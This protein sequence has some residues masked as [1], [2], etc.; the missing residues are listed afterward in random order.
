MVSN[1]HEGDD[2]L[3]VE[4]IA[5]MLRERLLGYAM[6]TWHGYRPA[7][8]HRVIAAKLEAVERGEIK[9][10][11]IFMPPRHGKTALASEYFPAWYLGRNAERQIIH[12]TY[13][14]E[15]A[16]DL[17]MK[18]R[19]QLM[20]PLY[21]EIFPG[22]EL[23]MTSRAASRFNTSNGGVYRAVGA[24][25][26]ITGR[27]AHLLLV[28]DPI[29]GRED[30]DSETMR[31]RLK[32]WY[33]SVAYTRLMPGGAVVIIQCMTGDTPV[34]MGDG[35]VQ[36]LDCLRP[37]DEVAT[38]EC[39]ELKKSTVLNWSSNGKDRIHA[40]TT[41]SGKIV[42]AN[43]RHP[44]LV[45]QEGKWSWVQLKN[46]KPGMAL[47]SLRDAIDHQELLQ[48]QENAARA[49]PRTHTEKS[50][51]APPVTQLGITENGKTLLAL[52]TGA[53]NPQNAKACV[54]LITE[55]CAGLLAIIGDQQQKTERLTS[56]T[57]TGF[58]WKS[59]IVYWLNKVGFALF[60]NNLPAVKT[61][62]RTGTINSASIT[63]TIP[64]GCEDYCAMTATSL[65]GTQKIEKQ[66]L[67]SPSISAFT[68][69]RIT[70]IKPAGFEEVF[71]IQIERTENFIANGLVSHNT[72]WHQ[73]DLSGWLLKEHSH[74]NWEV[75]SL[76]AV[77]ARGEALWP[78]SYPIERLRA[79]RKAVGERDWAALYQQSP[80][81]DGGNILK[82]QWWR[83]WP[84]KQPLPVCDH[85]FL[86]WD[87]AYS[88]KDFKANSHS[89][90]TAWGVFWHEKE[91]RNALILLKTWNGQVD[92]PK[93]RKQAREL[94]RE[95]EPD[96]HLIEKKA[97][98]QSLIQD[99]RR[100]PGVRVRSYQPDKDKVTR[101]YSVQA[102]LESGQ[103]WVPDR[104]WAESFVEMVSQFPNGAPP[105]S[106]YTD[107]ATQAM[108][109]LRNG[110]WIEH[111]DDKLPKL[112][113]AANEEWDEE[114]APK[115]RT[116]YG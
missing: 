28:D 37:G 102:M 49:K 67:L 106:D 26:P 30:A 73:D 89:A 14:Q 64:S 35:T 104:R 51:P 1:T 72:R 10:L 65:L 34:L 113:Q 46:L 21:Q 15:F 20:D 107:T 16:D 59:T 23:D 93:L 22:V 69:D 96:C 54:R 78:E 57:D 11:M 79:I 87:T 63:A 80:T 100:I 42:R 6:A 75:L 86:S 71:D 70:S 74:E 62:A 112:E 116:V 8:H 98:G 99:M 9:R 39:G 105:S 90:A 18:V 61:R 32:D 2:G 4:D 85:V 43:E 94:D 110:W 50:I 103:V 40:I 47:V 88:D 48:S 29:K 111:P 7:D 36:R 76:P 82:K 41:T 101:A 55:K 33:S 66:R 25:G 5:P 68:T 81:V 45:E 44:F 52:L 38:F 58:H 60:A 13:A 92:Y 114:D 12:T 109:Y 56:S 3:L 24:G 83:V 95:L 84:A 17:G 19:N 31:R 77:N 97:S 108:L 115:R 91:Q 27:G 53:K